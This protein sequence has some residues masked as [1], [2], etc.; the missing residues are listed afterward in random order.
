MPPKPGRRFKARF[1]TTPCVLCPTPVAVGETILWVEDRGPGYAHLRCY[2]GTEVPVTPERVWP[3][4]NGGLVFDL[5][6]ARRYIAQVK[7]QFAK[8]MPKSPHE[9]TRRVWAPTD[10][11]FV[12]F[13]E[14]I[15]REGEVRPWPPAPA[16]PLYHLTYL[17]I[18]GW[19]YW[20]MGSPM[21]D[22]VLINRA[23]N[24]LPTTA[25]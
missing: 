7:W 5:E 2:D 6:D 20:T 15:R 18:D 25:T 4:D 16:K 19:S 11:E 24:T 13:V 10:P 21:N 12:A 17:P 1:A 14:L 23:D 8:S 9:Y 22:T 3:T